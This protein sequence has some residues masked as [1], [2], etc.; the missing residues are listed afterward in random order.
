MGKSQASMEHVMIVAVAF[1]TIV[2]MVYLFY[3]YS[4]SSV[5]DINFA[6]LHKF[7]NTLVNTAETVYY[8]GEPT[9][10]TL[11][12]TVPEGIKNMTIK[13][14]GQIYELIFTLQDGSDA[15]YSSNV[16]I[17]GVFDEYDYSSGLKRII[18]ESKGYYVLINVT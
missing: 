6:R 1:L 11:E 14:D 5:E 13:I 4:Q 10:I 8:L 12:E 2:P 17:S 16:N 18:I 15:V 7:G 3:S 9:R